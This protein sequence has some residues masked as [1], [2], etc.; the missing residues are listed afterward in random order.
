MGHKPT[1]TKRTRPHSEHSQ[2]WG[3]SPRCRSEHTISQGI[4]AMTG[5]A[6]DSRDGEGCGS[7]SSHMKLNTRS[8]YGG[9][10]T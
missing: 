9:T 8:Q 7:S 1:S 10:R 5:Q 3:Q 2:K 6:M 4:T